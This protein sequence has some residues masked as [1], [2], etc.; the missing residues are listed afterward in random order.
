VT[1]VEASKAAGPYQRI[2]RTSWD[3]PYRF[4]Y[5]YNANDCMKTSDEMPSLLNLFRFDF[6]ADDWEVVEE[7][8]IAEDMRGTR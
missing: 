2:V 8:Q 1:I 6:L 3:R 5:F 7:D 4:W